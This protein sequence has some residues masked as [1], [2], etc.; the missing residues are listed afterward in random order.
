MSQQ[1]RRSVVVSFLAAGAAALG[2]SSRP[3]AAPEKSGMKKDERWD[4]GNREI[5]PKS[6][7]LVHVRRFDIV[8]ARGSTIIPPYS[9]NKEEKIKGLRRMIILG[10]GHNHHITPS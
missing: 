5:L 9:S 3:N 10:G 6:L 8:S 7:T 1:N 4:D 2:F